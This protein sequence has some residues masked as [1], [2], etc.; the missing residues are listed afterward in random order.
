MKKGVLVLLPFLTA[1]AS[2][3]AF[4]P[5]AEDVQGQRA[6]WLAV[7]DVYPVPMGCE[8]IKVAAPIPPPGE[9]ER[10]YKR[11]FYK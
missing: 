9:R 4:P 1:C 11:S 7:H 3:A 2:Q 10:A 6:D 5:V 8:I